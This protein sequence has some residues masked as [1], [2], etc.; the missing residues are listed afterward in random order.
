[1][2]AIHQTFTRNMGSNDWN[3][4]VVRIRVWTIRGRG[5]LVFDRQLAKSS[6]DRTVA[7]RDRPAGSLFIHPKHYQARKLATLSL[8]KRIIPVFGE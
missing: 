2:S 8:P 4:S 5:T 3:T 1:M 7:Y 6:A